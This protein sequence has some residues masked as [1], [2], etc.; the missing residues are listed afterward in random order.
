VNTLSISKLVFKGGSRS[1]LRADI[2]PF[3]Y[4]LI[5]NKSVEH[6]DISSHLVG[7]QLA[8]GLRKVLIH[9]IKL[10][11]LFWD[12]NDITYQGF[13]VF[14]FGLERNSSLTA[15]PASL[16]DI[17]NILKNETEDE[18]KETLMNLIKDIELLVFRNGRNLLL[19]KRLKK[20]DTA[21]IKNKT[22]KK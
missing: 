6:L 21:R 2:L 22:K 3:I 18:K 8:F 20:V 13:K 10:K 15:M 19:P 14:K 12:E 17:N 7:D 1:A 16:R 9:N 5:T 4:N 11:S